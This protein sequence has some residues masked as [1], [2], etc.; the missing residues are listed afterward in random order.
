MSFLDQFSNLKNSALYSRVQNGITEHT[1]S[2][3]NQINTG[4]SASQG[5]IQYKSGATA[6]LVNPKQRGNPLL[7]SIT[8]IPWEYDDN[9]I[10]DYVMN[11]T[12]CA[13]FL[14]LKYHNLKPDYINERLKLLGKLYDLRV[15]LVQVDLEDPHHALKHLTRVCLLCDLTLMLA[16]SPHE[17]GK[18]IETYK[19]Y[20]HKPP[21]L[22]MEKQETDPQTKIINALASIR[23]V[24][25]TDAATLLSTFGSLKNIIRASKESLSLCPGIGPQKA[26]RIQLVL[27]QPFL[28]NKKSSKSNAPDRKSVV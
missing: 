8:S 18:I 5:V 17:A 12:T 25:R 19:I 27:K 14:S 4:N 22:I 28:K 9:I 23:S 24:N 7:K 21:D 26:S 20:E 1:Q 15:L 13:L 11:R 16:W 10:P 2:N 6:V 3:V